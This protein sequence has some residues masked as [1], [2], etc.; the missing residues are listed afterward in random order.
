MSN[1]PQPAAQPPPPKNEPMSID[2]PPKT[3]TTTNEG[4][5]QLNSKLQS[6]EVV[7]QRRLVSNPP[8]PQPL[9]PPP[10]K[11]PMLIDTP[12]KTITTTNEGADQ[13]NS[14]L[15]SREV[16][17]LRRSV[18]NPPQPQLQP[19]PP[20][21]KEA[22]M[23]IDAPPKTIPTTNDSTTTEYAEQS[24]SKFR[25][26]EEVLRRRSERVKKLAKMY[27]SNYWTLMEELKSKYKQYYWTY[28]K[29]PYKDDNTNGVAD[30][31]E[32]KE[33]DGVKK[34]GVSGCKT[35]AMAL[36]RF[37]LAHIMS[38]SKQTLYTACSYV[39]K[40]GQSGPIFCGK[41]ILKTIVPSLCSNHFQKAEKH[42]ARALR[43]AGPGLNIT[44]P[45]KF[46]PKL[47]VVVAEYVRQIQSKRRA[48]A[49]AEALM[50]GSVNVGIK[51]EKMTI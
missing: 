25:S 29:S 48:A 50:V 51:E 33:D 24:N 45:C 14:K 18:S 15:Q 37:C 20:P 1:P 23:S 32:K 35:K 2:T 47:H 34:C 13:S 8:Q 16:V 36:T 49:A 31:G 3:I 4:A 5:D 17:L 7:L 39:I 19:P 10:M 9:P 46:A 22:N 6:R 44:S 28:G 21:R 38:D 40:N 11:E 42:V 26:R 27:R 43:K 41:P 30:G 12:P